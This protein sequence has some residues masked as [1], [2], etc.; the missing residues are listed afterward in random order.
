MMMNNRIYVASAVEQMTL[1]EHYVGRLKESGFE[2]SYEWT[3]DVRANGFK[4]DVHLT[5]TTRRFIAKMDAKGV[6]DADTVWV[7]TPT[8]KHVGCGMWVELGIAIALK[9]RL[10]VSG[11]LCRRTVFT[12]LAEACFEDHENAFSHLCDR[13]KVA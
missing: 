3:P 7:L 4:P 9:K 13:A 5:Q 2:M 6:E 11:A 10:I 1:V 8:V 12:E